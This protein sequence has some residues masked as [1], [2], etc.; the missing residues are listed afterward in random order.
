MTSRGWF[1]S[2]VLG[3]LALAWFDVGLAHAGAVP[4]TRA[5]LT[6]DISSAVT[7]SLYQKDSD[8]PTTVNLQS[9][10]RC[11]GSGTSTNPPIYRD[12][13]DCWM[14]EWSPTGGGKSVYVV[15]NGS[16]T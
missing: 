12:V 16:T 15:V 9:P 2:A 1:I 14:P 3:G 10:S 7:V 5:D 13:T 8:L 6:L 11:I 4:P